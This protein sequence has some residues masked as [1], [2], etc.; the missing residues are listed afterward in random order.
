MPTTSTVSRQLGSLDDRSIEKIQRLQRT[1]VIEGLEREQL[2]RITLDFDGSVVGTCRL[3]DG[4]AIGFNRKKK[5]QRSY[6]LY[7]TVAQTVQ[8]LTMMYRSGNVHDSSGVVAST[9][10]C[11][12]SVTLWITA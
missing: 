4:V 8:V 5:G 6:P 9:R 2:A 11:V 1:L 7:C 10:D 12:E 3:A